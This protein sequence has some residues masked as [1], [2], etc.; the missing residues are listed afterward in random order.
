MRLMGEKEAGVV[1]VMGIAFLAQGGYL[2][3]I[4]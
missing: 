4:L 2:T 1:R 3:R